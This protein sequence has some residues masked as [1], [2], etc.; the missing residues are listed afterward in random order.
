MF[1][2]LPLL[3]LGLVTLDDFLAYRRNWLIGRKP[4]ISHYRPPPGAFPPHPIA[5]GEMANKRTLVVATDKQVFTS[6]PSPEQQARWLQLADIA[7]H[8]ER[9]RNQELNPGYRARQE[10][11]E[12]KAEV[13]A[14]LKNVA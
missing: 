8:N 12:V 4:S 13:R 11:Q 3:D 9:P 1:P 10:H 5:A 7:L 2:S 6:A 14:V